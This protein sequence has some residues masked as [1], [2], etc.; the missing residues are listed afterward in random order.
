MRKIPLIKEYRV[1]KLEE[2]LRC[3]DKYAYHREKQRDCILT[4][5]PNDRNKTVEHRE[6]SIFRG[7]IIPSLRYLGLIIGFGDM[8]KASAN[9]KLIIESQFDN[10]LHKRCW[11]AIV[12]EIDKSIFHFMDYIEQR[13]FSKEEFIRILSDQILGVSETQKRER[14]EKWLSI[15]Y[16]TELIVYSGKLEINEKHYNQTLMDVD[17]NLKDLDKF[18]EYAIEEYYRLG[19]NSAGIVDIR[20]LREAVALRILKEYYN[21]LTENQFDHLFREFIP[22]ASDFHISLGEPMGAD[23]KLFAY[24]DKFY[25]T[26]IMKK[27]GGA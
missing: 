3:I 6:K 21:V 5:Y 17:P 15:M 10:E 9:G 8:I 2:C 26:V 4:L 27:K 24:K 13:Q 11:R 22:K 19:K 16:Q 25:K 23:Q 12:Y 18:C 14:I 7:M 1:Q 20:E